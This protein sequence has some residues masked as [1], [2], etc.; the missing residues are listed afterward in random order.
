MD[1]L[2]LPE[3]AV[4]ETGQRYSV[5][6]RCG[7]Q[8]RV[9]MKHF[10][11]MCRCTKCR[12]PIY[13][14]Y[15]NVDP[16]VSAADREVARVF[17]EDEVPVHWQ[18]GDLLMGL[19][20]VRDTLGE[21]GMG[22]VYKVYHRG[23]GMHLAVKCPAPKLLGD[24]EW[25]D[26][27][28]HECETWINLPPHP[29][30]VQCY[31]VRRLA[32]IPRV[33]VEYVKCLDLGHM[34]Q[35]K[36]LYA[37]GPD[38]AMARML[39]ASIQYCRGLE[40][41]HR[42]GVVHQDVKPSNLLI[43]EE[44]ECK[45]TDFGLAKVWVYEDGSGGSSR[46]GGSGSG[47]GSGRGSS[48]MK[49]L[50]GGTPTYR[51]N[52]HKRFGEITHKTDIWSWGVSI[53][54]M[55]AGDIYWRHGRDACNVLDNLLAHGSRYDIIPRMPKRFEALLYRCFEEE[56]AMRP[57][58]MHSIALELQDIYA[59]EVG[60]RYPRPEVD[61]GDPALDSLNNRAV[62]MIDLGKSDEAARLWA[63]VIAMQPDS[64]EAIYNRNLH[65]WKAGRITDAEMLEIVSRLREA[66]PDAWLP[67]YLLGRVLLERGDATTALKFL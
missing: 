25:L 12:F 44:N 3:S 59:E 2:W 49:G 64:I 36:T 63:D 46:S 5:V 23:W 7:N 33:Y 6:C 53:I 9:R 15:D 17:K 43:G 52:D 16:A 62:S 1:D 31:Y 45:V 4:K 39:D 22:V 34:I 18:K 8:M 20:E 10:G 13:V 27:F 19:Y 54:E 50:S 11:R 28:E 21:G 55:F 42:Q 32:G 57:D 48:S 67:A 14:T 66:H 56:P 26:Q 51:S 30:V 24:A 58:D 35:H 40:H 65:L 41:A 29:N 60:R 47:R 61:M 38:A 37:G